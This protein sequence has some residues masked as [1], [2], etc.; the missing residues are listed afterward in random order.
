M[1]SHHP[2]PKGYKYDAIA[3]CFSYPL[4]QSINKNI[5]Q[6]FK[7]LFKGILMLSLLICCLLSSIGCS[8]SAPGDDTGQ[9][10]EHAGHINGM[11]SSMEPL[12]GDAFKLSSTIKIQGGIKAVDFAYP[13]TDYC[14]QAGS[15]LFVL[16][17]MDFVNQSG[18]DTIL[19]FPAG[20]TLASKS[21]EDQNGILIQTT[22]IPLAKGAT[23]NTL[24][25]AFCTNEH[26]HGSS[27]ES[28]YE[29]GPICKA[30]PILDLIERL[31]HK[32]VNLDAGEMPTLYGSVASMQEWVWHITEGEGLT[33]DDKKA[34][35]QLEG[36]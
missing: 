30:P 5:G 11:G 27:S 7:Y 21:T 8:K 15:G 10:N 17:A 31:A 16:V 18:K 25:Y 28:Q 20:L 34:I 35:N 12:N 3:T 22:K 32:K 33:E 36:L 26:R 6:I 9:Q 1:Q 2:F 19:V 24:F 4:S 29:F 23:C 14:Q 13:L